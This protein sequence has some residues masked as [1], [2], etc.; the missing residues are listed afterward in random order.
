MTA[1]AAVL[2]VR[3]LCNQGLAPDVFMP[4]LLETLHELVPSYRNLFDWTD[5]EGA[6]QRYFFEGPID[7]GIAQRYFEIFHNSREIECMPVFASIAE[8]PRGVRG[9]VMLDQ[10]VFYESALYREIWLPQGLHSRIEGIVRDGAGSLVGSLV[11]YRGPHDRRFRVE[12]ER[13][14]GQVLLYV[15]NGLRLGGGATPEEALLPSP[16]PAQTAVVGMDGRLLYAT[17]GFAGSLLAA[18]EGL[19]PASLNQ[20][21][22]RLLGGVIRLLGAGPAGSPGQSLVMANARGRWRLV[23]LP[24]DAC[25]EP[26]AGSSGALLLTLRRLE[27]RHVA[28]DR[29][30]RSLPLTAGQARVARAVYAGLGQREIALQLGVAQATVVDHVRKI[31]LRLEVNS[32]AALRALVD[33]DIDRR[34]A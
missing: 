6:L 31:Y 13:L 3:D 14:L 9:A 30:L 22:E 15:A 28:L 2:A 5:A 32:A 25:R 33:R 29:V 12:D 26:A 1:H 34:A 16:D 23:A 27:P 8:Q 17:P 4:A 10:P 24:L 19:S 7:V 11:L 21:L 20:P 18:Q